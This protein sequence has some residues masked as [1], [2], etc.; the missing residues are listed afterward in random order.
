M[1]LPCADR[2]T[3]EMVQSHKGYRMLCVIM[4]FL[5]FQKRE[6]RSASVLIGCIGMISNTNMMDA[7]MKLRNETH[8][9]QVGY[10]FD[11]KVIKKK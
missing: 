10:I 11:A 5:L 6:A 4:F 9:L 1:R 3:R 7:L 8:N 2:G